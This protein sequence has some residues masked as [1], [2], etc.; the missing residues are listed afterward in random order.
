M[1]NKES[2]LKI[3]IKYVNW[4]QLFL[5]FAITQDPILLLNNWIILNRIPITN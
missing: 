3:N 5:L 4:L 1:S 2:Y